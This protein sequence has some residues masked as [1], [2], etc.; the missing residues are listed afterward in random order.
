MRARPLLA[1]AL[2][3]AG[4]LAGCA[5]ST[6]RPEPGT[7]IGYVVV[8]LY[9]DE[10]LVEANVGIVGTPGT[11]DEIVRREA[12]RT[13]GFRDITFQLD[14][15][16]GSTLTADPPTFHLAQNGRLQARIPHAE[17]RACSFDATRVLDNGTDEPLWN[18]AIS[19]PWA[20]RLNGLQGWRDHAT[21]NVTLWE[22]V[23]GKIAEQNA[24]E[25]NVNGTMRPVD[26]VTWH[27]WTLEGQRAEA[28]M[29][30]PP[31]RIAP[32][33]YEFRVDGTG[34]VRLG[35]NNFRFEAT[36]PDGRPLTHAETFVTLT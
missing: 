33:V 25:K 24:L 30:E 21:F 15:L 10:S 12:A 31:T 22:V 2:L 18:C 29:G 34:G 35:V 20:A 1:A 5:T 26:G 14:R 7:P 19:P 8:Q 4:A 36:L 17:L 16:D 28:R 23:D 6:T 32:A 11:Y 13:T 9:R 27:S 3:L